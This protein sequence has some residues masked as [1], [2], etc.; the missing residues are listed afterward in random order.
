PLP[1][2]VEGVLLVG[3]WEAESL[4]LDGERG[5]AGHAG[6]GTFA[7]NSLMDAGAPSARVPASTVTLPT[8]PLPNVTGGLVRECMD[9]CLSRT[10]KLLLPPIFWWSSSLGM[11]AHPHS[12]RAMRWASSRASPAACTRRS[13]TR[14]DSYG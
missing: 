12:Y 6:R 13:R 7:R 4:E 8:L 10:G 1:G 2:R 14:M 3:R 11:R 5:E 9:L